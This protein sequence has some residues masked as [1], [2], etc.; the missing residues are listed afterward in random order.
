MSEE[1]KSFI[2]LFVALLVVT[3]AFVITLKINLDNC[4]LHNMAKDAY[5]AENSN[6][7]QTEYNECMEN[8]LYDNMLKYKTINK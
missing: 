2:T 4:N 8:T 7:S 1:D 5:C 6:N 3:M